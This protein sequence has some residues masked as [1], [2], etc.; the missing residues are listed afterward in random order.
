MNETS[1][2]FDLI[3]KARVN[4]YILFWPIKVLR[5]FCT[6]IILL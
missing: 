5:Q 2:S 1:D 3:K 4:F 6:N